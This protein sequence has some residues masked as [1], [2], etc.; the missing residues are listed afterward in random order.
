MAFVESPAAPPEFMSFDLRVKHIK[1]KAKMPADPAIM[2]TVEGLDA[3]LQRWAPLY[4]KARSIRMFSQSPKVPSAWVRIVS[5]RHLHTGVRTTKRQAESGLVTEH[6]LEVDTDA[7]RLGIPHQLTLYRLTDN[8]VN[9]AK[10]VEQMHYRHKTGTTGMV[11][12]VGNQP[13]KRVPRVALRS[14]ALLFELEDDPFESRLSLIYRTGLIEQKLRLQR[15]AAYEA[16]VQK[17]AEAARAA[18]SLS[19]RPM[20]SAALQPPRSKL[21]HRTRTMRSHK[22]KAD[23]N[24]TL[25]GRPRG[26]SEPTDRPETSFGQEPMQTHSTV[27]L[28][29]AYAKLQKLNS[30]MWI[31]K[32]RV[33]RE[34]VSARIVE[35][36]RSFWG[37]EE[38]I[39]AADS[40]ETLLRLP[41]APSLLTAYFN[42]VDIT[43]DKPSFD[44]KELPDFLYRVGKGLPKDTQFA[45]LVPMSIKMDFKEARIL[46]RD[47]PL[48]FIHVP[49]M[50]ID[51]SSRV[52]SWSLSSNIVIA[53]ELWGKES[54]RT[55][56]VNIIT[57]TEDDPNDEY[58]LDI[59]RTVAPV[60]SYSDFNIKINTSEPTQIT[61]CTAYQPA[62][63]DMMMVF[64][65]FSKPHVDTS[66]RVGFWDKIRLV[67]HSE[68][69]LSWKDHDGEVQLNLKG[70]F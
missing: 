57:P 25:R 67:L 10:S 59:I 20:T 32:I 33:A 18:N 63:Q 49:R 68:L 17:M 65:T 27:S 64:E 26:D 40:S 53:E 60:K 5:I 31:R 12:K 66:E 30:T 46:L 41:T 23:K 4:C 14:K 36:R 13:A 21:R 45:L 15:Q 52:P 54:K 42:D 6:S 24:D 62:I 1:V 50:G 69:T 28:E 2:L 8:I 56:R 9:T 47:Y 39:D 34:N 35:S 70:K 38:I 43:V 22:E 7:I 29:E 48:P 55:C 11:Q 58:H 3:G 61:W 51:Q 44:L 37:A 19:G 16:K